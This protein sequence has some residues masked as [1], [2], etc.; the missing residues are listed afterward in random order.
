MVIRTNEPGIASIGWVNNINI[1]IK[2]KTVAENYQ[3]FQKI[4]KDKIQLWAKLYTLIFIL[5]KFAFIYFNKNKNQNIEI[6]LFFILKNIIIQ[7][8]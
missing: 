8:I 6:S 5:E 7:L 2:N 1:I 4:Y 3:K